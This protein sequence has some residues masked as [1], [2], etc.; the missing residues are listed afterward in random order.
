VFQSQ[1][2]VPFQSYRDQKFLDKINL[3]D[4]TKKRLAQVPD[5]QSQ[6][7]SVVYLAQQYYPPREIEAS[8]KISLRCG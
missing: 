7:A 4:M 5:F 2:D 3:P 1:Y 8:S 6:P